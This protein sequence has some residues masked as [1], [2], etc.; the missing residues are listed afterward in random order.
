MQNIVI[1]TGIT[2]LYGSQRS[3]AIFAWKT[4]NFGPDLQVSMGPRPHLSFCARKTV[5]LPQEQKVYMGSSSHLWFCAC[6]TATFRLELQDC[7]GPRPHLSFL[8]VKQR[9]LD[10]NNKSLWVPDM[11]CRFVQVQQRA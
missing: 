3:S 5:C 11:D 10:Q 7:V 9:F 1:S 4:T 6:K 2:S 8:H